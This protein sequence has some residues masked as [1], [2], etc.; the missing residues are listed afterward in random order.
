[1]FLGLNTLKSFWL[2]QLLLSYLNYCLSFQGG[3]YVFELIEYYSATRVSRLFM[4]LSQCLA[5]AWIFGETVP[6]PF[7]L[8]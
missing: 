2:H 6:Q 8:G 1:M 3:L 4:T 7:R 5:V